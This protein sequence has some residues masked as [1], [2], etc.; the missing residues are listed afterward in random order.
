MLLTTADVIGRN[1][2]N[3]PI[4]GT[5]E[6]TGLALAIIIFFSLGTAQIKGIISRLTF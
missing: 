1:V 5:Y 2:F 6:L 3:K 4:T